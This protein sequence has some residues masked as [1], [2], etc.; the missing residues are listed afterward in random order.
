VGRIALAALVLAGL[1]APAT[2]AATTPKWTATGTVSK[3]NTHAIT[4]NGT[5]CRITSASPDRLTLRLYYVG[6]EVKIACRKSVLEAI[7]V[8]KQLPP[9]TSGPPTF[10]RPPTGTTPVGAALLTATM[11]GTTTT[12]SSALVGTTTITALGD[13]KITA[14]GGSLTL[15]CTLGDGSPDVGSYEV[16]TR[17]SRLDCRNGV[18][19][20]LT[21]A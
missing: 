8:L 14:G 10:T 19:T 6:A 2:F 4:V 1:T 17:I 11:S 5:S 13:G 18:L 3:L 15:T 20:G 12:S 9:I 21:L 16:G 7:D